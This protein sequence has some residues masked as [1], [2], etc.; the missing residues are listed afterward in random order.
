MNARISIA[1][2]LVQCLLCVLLVLASWYSL[3]ASFDHLT[4]YSRLA[5]LALLTIIVTTTIFHF[6]MRATALPSTEE[7][8]P[9]PFQTEE[10]VQSKDQEAV[11][12]SE[13]NAA[14][15]RAVID[16]SP[17]AIY[18][19]QGGRFVFVNK[20]AIKLFGARSADEL[21]GKK[22]ISF[23]HEDDRLDARNQ[24]RK[25]ARTGQTVLNELRWLRLDG[26]EFLGESTGSIILSEGERSMVGII[27]DVTVRREQEEVQRQSQRL[28]AIGQLTGGVAHDFNNLLAV[29]IWNLEMLRED[30]EGDEDKLETLDRARRASQKGADLVKQLLAFSRRQTL[31]TMPIDLNK[32]ITSATQMVAS[33][34]GENITITTDFDKQ[35]WK[36]AADPVQVENILLN[37]ALNAR[38]AM[39]SGGIV[40]IKTENVTFTEPKV[41]S[42][43]EIEPGN[44]ASITITDDGEGMPPEVVSRAFE[45]FFTTKLVGQGT[46]LGLSTV[47]GFIRQSKGHITLSSAVGEGTSVAI[48][49]PKSIE[50]DA[51]NSDNPDDNENLETGA[52]EQI[53]IV[54]DS[55]EVLASIEKIVRGF[56]YHIHSATSGPEALEFLDDLAPGTIKLMLTDIG[57]AG[58][59]DG[60][61]LSARAR[62]Q[63][64]DLKVVY[65][66]GYADD[67]LSR[68]DFEGK[69]Q[70]LLRKPFRRAEISKMLRQVLDEDI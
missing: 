63:A 4:W 11:P 55:L 5:P 50:K 22:V 9:A 17:D 49:L 14:S 27:R 26:E 48:F 46:G 59:M 31:R 57:L 45:P 18:I 52:G 29:V 8:S 56:G 54:E 3:P 33:T 34:L 24:I 10:P 35:L 70:Y 15:Y 64:P 47:Y 43:E 25:L 42:G 6:V 39:T 2:F 36:T 28:E 32:S 21:I 65:M 19:N 38:D 51:L 68:G 60:W 62:Q 58:G 69:R 66:S 13:T 67:I 7:A 41:V 37:L 1:V 20:S 40:L 53:L 23:L 30:L 12:L 16:I 44:Y 61:E